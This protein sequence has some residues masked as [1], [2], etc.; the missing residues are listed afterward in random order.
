MLKAAIPSAIT[1]HQFIS[2][3]INYSHDAFTQFLEK[4]VIRIIDK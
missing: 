3:Y 1:L 4:K 2:I